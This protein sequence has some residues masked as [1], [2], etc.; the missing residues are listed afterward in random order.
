MTVSYLWEQVIGD[1]DPVTAITDSNKSIA[2]FTT[3]QVT[4]G[5]QAFEF[6]LSV[7]DEAGQTTSAISIINVTFDNEP[8]VAD[9]G[10]PQEITSGTVDLDGSASTDS[11]GTI[12]SYR[13]EQTKGTIVQLTDADTSTPRFTAPSS[14]ETETLVFS[15]VVTDNEGLEATDTVNILIVV[16]DSSASSC[17][18]DS[19]TEINT[20]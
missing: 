4:S 9:A 15:L 14:E 20:K 17:F 5:G 7:T 16:E 2:T 3:P 19:I 12:A 10:D 11:D 18:I 13:W 8:P 6:R 1:N